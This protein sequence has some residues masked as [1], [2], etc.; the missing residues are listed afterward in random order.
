MSSIEPGV[1]QVRSK[2]DALVVALASGASRRAAARRA[3]VSESTVKR[4]LAV[5]EFRDRVEAERLR[6]AAGACQEAVDVLTALTGVAAEAVNVLA[7]LMRS[8]TNEWVRI[9]TAQLILNAY[10]QHR[11]E[12]DENDALVDRFREVLNVWRLPSRTDDAP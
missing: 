11:P 6:I 1:H 5:N 4:R 9:R 8:S 2:D 3:G 10:L 7:G 12:P